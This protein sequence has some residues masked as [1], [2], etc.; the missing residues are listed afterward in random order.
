M[1]K[2]LLIPFL[3][4]PLVSG[5]AGQT[6]FLPV[7]APADGGILRVSRIQGQVGG[8][9]GSGFADTIQIIKLGDMSGGCTEVE[10]EG[11]KA[12]FCPEKS[13]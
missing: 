11:F 1:K 4:L 3:F 13:E 8:P 12:K 5:C 2:L 9:F 10:R 6:R 7:E